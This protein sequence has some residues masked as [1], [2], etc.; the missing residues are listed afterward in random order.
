MGT[1]SKKSCLQNNVFVI[2][3]LSFIGNTGCKKGRSID[4]RD[5]G[6]WT[7]KEIV[8][9]SKHHLQINGVHL[10]AFECRRSNHI[11]ILSL[12]DLSIF[13]LSLLTIYEWRGYHWQND[14]TILSFVH[15]CNYSFLTWSFL[16][17][18][19]LEVSSITPS[20]PLLCTSISLSFW[21]P[22]YFLLSYAINHANQFLF[23]WKRMN[24]ENNSR[25]CLQLLKKKEW[26][27]ET[28]TVNEEGGSGGYAR[29]GKNGV[30]EEKLW[31]SAEIF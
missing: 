30:A 6:Y 29:A 10:I 17:F 5:W 31:F 26:R 13:S 21:V 28:T 22:K 1:T 7:Q 4:W 3:K 25:D 8:N 24:K 14:A 15:L 23:P 11:V 12:L 16:V 19:F 18:P 20:F 27:K 2:W 9:D